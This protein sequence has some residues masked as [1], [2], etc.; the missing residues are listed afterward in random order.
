MRNGLDEL[1]ELSNHYGREPEFVLGGGG[2]TSYK[3]ADTLFVK[4]SGTTLANITRDGFVKMDRKALA[5]LWDREYSR[6]AKEREAEVLREMMDARMRGEEGKRPSV[7]TLLHD[8]IG[9]SYVVH[10]HPCL[11]NGVTCSQD[12]AKVVKELFGDRAVWVEYCDPGYTLA[13]SVR[14]ALK[15]FTDRNG[16]QPEALFLQNHGLFVMADS[17]TEVKEITSRICGTVKDRIKRH[18]DTSQADYDQERLALLMPQLR[19]LLKEDDSPTAIAVFHTDREIKLLTDGADNFEPVSSAYTPDHIVY[20][21]PE[22]LFIESHTDLEE[23]RRIIGQAVEDYRHAKG[24][25]PKIVAVRGLGVIAAGATKQAADT[26]MAL[27]KDAVKISVYARS[28]GGHRFMS[29]E[30]IRFISQWEAESYRKK[31]SLA[32]AGRGRAE[33][34]VAVVTGAAQGFG[35]GL[36]NALLKEGAY[37]VIADI[38]QEQAR[39]TAAEFAAEFGAARTMPVTVDV[40]D[41]E[42]VR[43]M[44]ATA[45]CAFGGLDLLVS[46]A[47]ILKAGSL[48]DSNTSD[49]SMVTLV[50]YH[51][52]YLCAKHAAKYMKIQN[53]YGGGMSDIV[54][55]NSKSGLCGSKNN[56]AYAGSKFGGIG[57]TQSFALELV[58]DKIKVNAICPGNLFDGPL[59]SDPERGL[60][61]QYLKVGKVPGAK[62]IDDVRRHYESLVPMGRGCFVEDVAKAL[63][64]VMEQEYETGQAIPVTGGQCMLP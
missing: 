14:G 5:K 45:V 17:A 54:Q 64:Y 33:G 37:V 10:T 3:T 18:P 28:F 9:K 22:A 25:L 27:F 31:V 44:T 36:A 39:G 61:A 24:F 51:G 50:N 55:I 1:V 12:G 63:F 4:G 60:F 8:L 15:D 7:E 46:N 62:S 20:C 53:R 13:L 43:S 30:Q 49:F 59:W 6:D 2:N 11:I 58:G 32:T 52:Y 26:A 23:Q 41:E 16:R 42:S 47:G 34:R 40:T 56:S 21:K 29:P 48:E 57:L 38:N 19:M 35:K